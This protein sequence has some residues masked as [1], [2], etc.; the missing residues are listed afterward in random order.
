MTTDKFDRIYGALEGLPGHRM[1]RPSTVMD[2]LPIVG[3]V[4]TYV[5]QSVRHEEGVLTFLQIVDD[6]GRARLILPDKVSAAIAGQRERL[7]DRSTPDS[8]ARKARQRALAQKRSDDHRKGKHD[9]GARRAAGLPERM[10]G[11]PLCAAGI[12]GVA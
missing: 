8:R 1:T 10:R 12:R 11:C 3:N 2:S 9:P 7:F 6:D 4:T 5:V